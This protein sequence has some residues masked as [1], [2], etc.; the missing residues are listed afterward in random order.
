MNKIQIDNW[1]KLAN[2]KDKRVAFVEYVENIIKTQEETNG[3]LIEAGYK[4]CG[5]LQFNE[6][7]E[8][9]E[10][11]KILKLACDLELPKEHRSKENQRDDEI[12]WKEIKTLLERVR[13]ENPAE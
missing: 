3:D 12:I 5:A 6:L 7:L 13:K 11:E 2:A 9:P 8:V 4:V 10:F 1:M